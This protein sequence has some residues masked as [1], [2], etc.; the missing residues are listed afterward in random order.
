MRYTLLTI[1][2]NLSIL[3]GTPLRLAALTADWHRLN[4]MP[5]PIPVNGL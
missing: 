1:E 5:P 2:Q 3:A 4:C